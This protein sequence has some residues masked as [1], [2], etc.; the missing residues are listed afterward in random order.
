MGGKI[1]VEN[2]QIKF[3]N[4]TA[5]RMSC[6]NSQT[7]MAFINGL[8]TVTSYG[9]IEDRLYLSNEQGIQFVLIRS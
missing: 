5:T 1:Y 4:V 3:K 7:E 6:E 9:V 8:L 2:D